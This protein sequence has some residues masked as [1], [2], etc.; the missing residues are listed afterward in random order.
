MEDV[1]L[2]QDPFG[3]ARDASALLQGYSAFRSS[4]HPLGEQPGLAR[5]EA[6]GARYI[7]LCMICSHWY[8]LWFQPFVTVICDSICHCNCLGVDASTVTICGTLD[9]CVVVPL[10]QRQVQA[11]AR[12]HGAAICAHRHYKEVRWQVSHDSQDLISHVTR[13]TSHPPHRLTTYCVRG[14]AAAACMCTAHPGA[15]MLPSLPRGRAYGHDIKAVGAHRP[16]VG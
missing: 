2:R 10:S 15:P 16:V 7:L 14:H 13:H 8:C 3:P 6:H 5:V 1:I 9:S 4:L 11:V 12:P